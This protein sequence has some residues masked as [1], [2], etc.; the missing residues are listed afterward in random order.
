[1]IDTHKIS[2]VVSYY[3]EEE[4]I[5]DTLNLLRMQTLKPA[6]VHLINSG[7]T[8][9]TFSIINSWLAQHNIDNYYNVD[10]GTLVP[11]SSINVGIERSKSDWIALIDC[12]LMFPHNWLESQLDAAVSNNADVVIGSVVLHGLNVIDQAAVSQ[13]YGYNQIRECVPSSLIKKDIFLRYGLF[14]DNRRAGFDLHWRRMIHGTEADVI[15]SKNP[16]VTYFQT[17][18]INSLKSLYE[19][20]YLYSKS[21]TNMPSYF[22]PYYAIL[23]FIVVL[24]YIFRSENTIYSFS[25]ITT[26]YIIVRGFIVPFT[27]SKDLISIFNRPTLILCL[28]IVG[29]IIDTSKIHGFIAGIL[30]DIFK[31]IKNFLR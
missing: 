17:N 13:T 5:V 16:L 29:V 31:Y 25:F 21:S 27:K 28:P 23:A 7:S 19:K 4:S 6:E 1:M 22:I 15:L 24:L 9:N 2:V 14:L 20:V 10:A 18:F 8:D 11:S 3:N 30:N 26:I 12:G